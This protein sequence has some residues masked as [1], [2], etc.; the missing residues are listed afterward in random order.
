M[1]RQSSLRIRVVLSPTLRLLSELMQEPEAFNINAATPLECLQ[2]M[3]DRYPTMRKWLYD[4]EDQL[5]PVAW[6]FINDPEWKKKLSPEELTTP[7]K[8]GD[9]VIIAFGK[10]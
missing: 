8:D 6:L 1:T 4:L 7:L 5:L 3:L 9:E 2:I 10:L